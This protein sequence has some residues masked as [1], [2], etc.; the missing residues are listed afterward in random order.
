M[1]TD[2]CEV[3][4]TWFFTSLLLLVEP[5]V[6]RGIS[7]KPCSPAQPASGHAV[8]MQL[9]DVPGFGFV[10]QG[11]VNPV[12]LRG[13]SPRVLLI[14]KTPCAPT[15]T[16]HRVDRRSRRRTDCERRPPQA[17]QALHQDGFAPL[18]ASC[19]AA[20]SWQAAAP[21]TNRHESRTRR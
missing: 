7:K 10:S 11:H 16:G 19:R 17:S 8:V 12:L 6:L 13:P 18:P 14:S 3:R 4:W 2:A 1:T 9:L 21:C 15:P 20:A 5:Q